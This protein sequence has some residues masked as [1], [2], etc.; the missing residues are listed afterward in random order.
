M[1]F[2]AQW[3]YFN[4]VLLHHT[5]NLRIAVDS[6]APWQDGPV[7]LALRAAVMTAMGDYAHVLAKATNHAHVLHVVAINDLHTTAGNPVP[8]RSLVIYNDPNRMPI[9]HAHL[10]QNGLLRVWSL[11]GQRRSRV[12]AR[13]ILD[14]MNTIP[15]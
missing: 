8:Y 5:I 4:G 12:W 13:A 7:H 3:Y 6:H 14:E 11:Q 15:L 2:L 9:A 1:T 10:D